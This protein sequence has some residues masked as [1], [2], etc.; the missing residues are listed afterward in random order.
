MFDEAKLVVHTKTI[1]KKQCPVQAKL[2]QFCVYL[3]VNLFPSATNYRLVQDEVDKKNVIK[4][5]RSTK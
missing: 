3:K 2:R 5:L 4:P 1:I